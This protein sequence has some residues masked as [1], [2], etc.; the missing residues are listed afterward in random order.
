MDADDFLAAALAAETL[1]AS[2]E[3]AAQWEQPSA[4]EGYTVAGLA[5]HLARA[6]LTLDRYLDG[7]APDVEPTD[8]AGYVVAVLGTHDPIDSEF[9]GRVRARAAQDAA[10]GQQALVDRLRDARQRLADRLADTDPG[11]SIAALD[12]TVLPV[13]EYLVTRLVELVIHLDDLA[14]SVGLP[15][16]SGVPTGAYEATAALLATV[17]SR[18]VG[19]LPVIRSLARRER[20]PDAVR[21]L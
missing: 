12:D 7:P 20:H 18:R 9:H 15:G 5:G 11:Q 13:E 3:V 6:V 21:A 8:A 17:A 2:P 1:I 10:G 14:V 19:P 4:L 16:P